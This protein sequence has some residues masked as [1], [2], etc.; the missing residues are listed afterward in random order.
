MAS[1]FCCL[2]DPPSFTSSTSL[3][4]KNNETCL[5]PPGQAWG[6]SRW[7]FY[8]TAPRGHLPVPV[9]G[10]LHWGMFADTCTHVVSLGLAIERVERDSMRG[11]P[12]LILSREGILDCHQVFRTCVWDR[13]NKVYDHTAKFSIFAQCPIIW[14]LVL[15]SRAFQGQRKTGASGPLVRG[16]Y[17]YLGEERKQR[18]YHSQTRIL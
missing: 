3:S 2:L 8:T 6:T 18:F 16:V 9:G 13:C 1:F 12:W 5:L 17:G 10:F 7:D 11:G 15:A 4:L 14:P